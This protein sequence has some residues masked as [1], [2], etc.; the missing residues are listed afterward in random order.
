MIVLDPLQYDETTEIDAVHHVLNLRAMMGAQAFDAEIMMKVSDEASELEINADTVA[1]KLNGTPKNVCPPGTD[2]IVVFVDVNITKNRGLSY[3]V[4]ACGAHRIVGVIN[5]G[6]Y[7]EIG[8]LVPPNSSDLVRNRLVAAGIRTVVERIASIR[9]CDTKGRR[10]PV[11]VMG[12]DRGYLP[13]VIHR[14]LYVLR[15]TRPIPFPLVAMRGFP[16]DRFGVR[17]KDT[18]RRGDHV[19]ATRSQYGQYLAM[20]APYWREIMQSSTLETP[21]QPGSLSF[22][23]TDPAEHFDVATEICN[24]KLIRKYTVT[25]GRQT[26]TAWD[27]QELGDNHF[28]DC[29]T[30][31]FALASWY[32]LYDNLS[33]VIDGVIVT[34]GGMVCRAVKPANQDQPNGDTIAP[35]KYHQDDLFDPMLN[36]SVLPAYDGVADETEGTLDPDVEPFAGDVESVANPLV[37]ASNDSKGG[38]VFSRSAVMKIRSQRVHKFR[39]GRYKK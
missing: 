32:H 30:G 26:L 37:E 36:P 15:K 20:M 14:T 4:A 27:W 22:Y 10:I 7:P 12:F 24:E 5:H 35:H 19:F 28:C 18:L 2:S 23:G 33:Q 38:A 34:R 16:W 29:I 17:D 11:T 6:R 1:S 8:P 39:R 13:A 21:L 3:A 31:C 25:R 9:F